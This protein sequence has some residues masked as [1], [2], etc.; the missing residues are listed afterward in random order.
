M[1]WRRLRDK[2][3]ETNRRGRGGS[4]ERECWARGGSRSQDRGDGRVGK[5]EGEPCGGLVLRNLQYLACH[6]W[7]AWRARLA[8]RAPSARCTRCAW[9]AWCAWCAKR[10]KHAEHTTQREHT[11]HAKR[12]RHTKHAKQTTVSK[13]NTPSIL[14]FTNRN[15]PSYDLL[16]KKVVLFVGWEPVVRRRHQVSHV[17]PHGPIDVRCQSA[18]AVLQIN[19]PEISNGHL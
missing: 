4:K 14:Y 13:P 12:A 17:S 1:C 7:C 9:C 19:P 15:M 11:E 8:W 2:E 6:A 5:V 3:E 16:Q 18:A 10:A